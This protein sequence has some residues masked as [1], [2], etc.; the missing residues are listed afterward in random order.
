MSTPREIAEQ[1]LAGGEIS[2]DQFNN[3]IAHLDMASAG[4]STSAPAQGAQ[5]VSQGAYRWYDPDGVMQA[6]RWMV[7][8]YIGFVVLSSLVVIGADSPMDAYNFYT[9]SVTDLGS[10][11][12]MMTALGIILDLCLVV[13]VCIC[14]YRF[15]SNV[16]SVGITKSLCT[17]G[18]T[19]G[20]FFVPVAFFWMPYIAISFVSRASLYG[21]AWD[22]FT[23]PVSLVLWFLLFW[24]VELS[25]MVISETGLEVLD[26]MAAIGIVLNLLAVASLVLLLHLC[27][28]IAA[29]QSQWTKSGVP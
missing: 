9:Y 3:I 6:L 10:T 25:S 17:P 7:G 21:R 2:V 5:A 22:N 14:L 26:G 8:L 15:S 16:A 1:R 24:F 29:A 28:G 13:G 18:W 11:F 19:V 20:W 12:G 4:A 27:G 23:P